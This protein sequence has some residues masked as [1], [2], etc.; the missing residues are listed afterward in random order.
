[1]KEEERKKEIERRIVRDDPQPI[2]IGNGVHREPSKLAKVEAK[3]EALE[4]AKIK[5]SQKKNDKS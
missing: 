4:R 1:M 3:E 2:S 5:S